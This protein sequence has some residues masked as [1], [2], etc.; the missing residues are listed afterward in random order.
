LVNTADTLF[1][2]SSKE[3]TMSGDE[4]M[5]WSSTLDAQ[6]MDWMDAT[7][8][9]TW[10]SEASPLATGIAAVLGGNIFNPERLMNN[11]AFVTI[12]YLLGTTAADLCQHLGINLDPGQPGVGLDT[13]QQALERMGFAFRS[14]AFTH[15]SNTGGGGPIHHARGVREALIT[16]RGWPRQVGVAYRRPNGTGHVVVLNSPGSPY[17]RYMDYQ[18]IATG[19]DVTAEVQASRIYMVF[20]V[21]QQRTR[22]DLYTQTR[23]AREREEQQRA[24]ELARTQQ[25]NEQREQGGFYGGRFHDEL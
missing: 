12:A 10:E 14:I 2:I 11:C 21:D 4:P 18:T 9:T 17:R 24:D 22:T 7:G 15:T 1:H 13:I 3:V 20:A 19:Q 25:D 16:G 23:E 5:D 6:C 8:A